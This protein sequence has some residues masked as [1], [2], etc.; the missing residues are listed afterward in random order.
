MRSPACSA[1]PGF[2]GCYV[3]STEAFGPEF[4]AATQAVDVQRFERQLKELGVRWPH[5]A[6]GGH[7]ERRDAQR[8][9]P[10]VGSLIA[11]LPTQLAQRRRRHGKRQFVSGSIAQMDNNVSSEI[12]DSSRD[13][14]SSSSTLALTCS[15]RHV[16]MPAASVL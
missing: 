2:F 6:Q 9:V 13:T 5:V 10:A 7:E 1:K 3:V 11:A 4:E 15:P 12:C 14:I 16:A 8:S